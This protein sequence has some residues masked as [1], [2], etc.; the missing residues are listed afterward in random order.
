MTTTE[1]ERREAW[2]A[3]AIFLIIVTVLSA[4]FHYAIVKLMP[5]SL[6]VGPLMWSPAVAALITLRLRGRKIS[7]L[8]WGWVTNIVGSSDGTRLPWRS[9]WR[10][11]P[12]RWISPPGTP[13]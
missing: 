5:T 1:L 4:V 12:C 10:G 6:Y 8:P 9:S 13:W 11:L 7:S 2:A 3:I